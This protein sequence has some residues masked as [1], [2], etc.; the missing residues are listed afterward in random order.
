MAGRFT[1]LAFG[2]RVSAP[3]LPVLELPGEGLVADRYGA[4]PGSVYLVRPDGI[5]AARWHRFEAQAVAAA[6]ARAQGRGLETSHE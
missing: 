2:W 4:R 3:G 5:V 1:L 6:L